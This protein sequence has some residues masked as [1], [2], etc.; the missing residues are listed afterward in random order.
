L[1]TICAPLAAALLLA[2]TAEGQATRIDFT[3][4]GTCVTTSPGEVMLANGNIITRGLLQTCDNVTDYPSTSVSYSVANSN[5]DSAG[6]GPVWG[7]IRIEDDVFGVLEGSFRGKVFAGGTAYTVNGVAQS[8]GPE[9][10]KLFFTSGAHFVTP[11]QT[12]GE[13][14]GTI[15]IP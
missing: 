8:L 1:V 6:N 9:H 10:A 4:T 11:D 12:V 3:L 5:L 7:T 14:T 13:G 15:L 2:G